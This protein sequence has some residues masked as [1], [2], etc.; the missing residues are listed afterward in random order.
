MPDKEGS[1]DEKKSTKSVVNKKQ[2]QM[3]GE[4][5]Y[6][7]ARDMGRVKPSKDKKD[8][9][10][11]PV[12]DEVRKT[13]KVN[14]GPSALDRVLKKYGKSVMKVGKKKVK[15]ELDLTKVAE[16]FGG[17]I[18]EG[19]FDAV[20]RSAKSRVRKIGDKT[21]QYPAKGEA[22]AAKEL[23]KKFRRER[24]PRDLTT[25]DVL[26]PMAKPADPSIDPFDDD[27]LNKVDQTKIPSDIKK[28]IETGGGTDPRF[29][30]S[31][32]G[33][34]SRGGTVKEP[35]TGTPQAK[36]FKGKLN[37]FTGTIDPKTGKV[38]EPPVKISY[39][40]PDPKFAK[41]KP[42]PKKSE[43][44]QAD[45]DDMDRSAKSFKKDLGGEKIISATMQDRLKQ[46]TRPRVAQ[47]SGPQLTRL[48]KS[49]RFNRPNFT[50]P[51]NITG[52]DPETGQIMSIKPGV[53]TGKSRK[54]E[55]L[56][57][58]QFKQI[59]KDIEKARQR[60]EEQTIDSPVTGGKLPAFGRQAT[61][62]YK[63]SDEY[64]R[65]VLGID[66]KT[67]E[68][69]TSDQ[70]RQSFKGGPLVKQDKGGPLATQ[71]K[72]GAITVAP[73]EKSLVTKSVEFAKKNPATAFLTLD[74]I[75]KY[76]PSKSPFGVQGGRAGLR[77]AA[78]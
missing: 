45:L 57:S 41:S 74:A 15:E 33:Q 59:Q 1:D 35:V 61:D 38:T 62:Y 6:D 32:E 78:R 4:E 54:A 2:K 13:Q 18:I 24:K 16:A 64:K 69:L 34:F 22:A 7:I 37:P 70:R 66:P 42:K 9:T 26:K 50:E 31:S 73:K 60:P 14:K 43:K 68:N 5:G 76:L 53:S 29:K 72:G 44:S 55:K 40:K 65:N 11:M 19:K 52:A 25:P 56:T 3:M 21:Y 48:Q 63:Q 8:A 27:E 36:S 71:D 67:G 46:A 10:T 77:S 58:K 30:K 39:Q 20:S 23:L 51:E 28:D 47:F 12:S 17:Y 75:R 49:N